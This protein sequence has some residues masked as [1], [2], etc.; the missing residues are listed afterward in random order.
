MRAQKEQFMHVMCE[1]MK[2]PPCVS[3]GQDADFCEYLI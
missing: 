3:K 2:W 1:T